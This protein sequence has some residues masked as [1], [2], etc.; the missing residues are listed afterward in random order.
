MII[1]TGA[2]GLVGNT[3]TRQ[4]LE[5]GKKVR[6]LINKT[7]LEIQHANL[8]Q[9]YCDILDVI[10]LENAFENADQLYHCAGLVS[11][12]PADEHKLYKLNV[13]GTANVVNAAVTAGIK[14]MVHVSSVSAMGRIRQ[15]EEIHEEMQW[16]K[17]TSNSTYGHSK[18]LGEMEVWRGLAEGLDAVIVNPVIILG[19]GN[20]NEGSTKIFK[21][22]FEEFPWYT[23]GVSGFVDVRD[24]SDAMIQLM[25]SDIS[26]ERFIIS[27][28]NHAF[29]QVFNTIA[30]SFGKKLPHKKA[31]PFISR[32]VVIVEKIKEIFSGKPPM[33]TKETAATAMA[34][35]YFNNKKLFKFLPAFQ[36]HSLSDTI[37][38][39]CNYFQQKLN[40]Q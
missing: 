21:S 15:D 5:Q 2:A 7:P 33:I 34:K 19:P 10:A 32:F 6:A 38:Y 24:V 17:K 30:M 39:S 14:K 27:G 4:L 31:T 25:E 13:E 9:V 20:W 12:L 36:Y 28:G 29:R 11:F 8:E 3:L 18:Y 23:E 26:A 40:K 16:T 37:D 22:V 1:V 35:V